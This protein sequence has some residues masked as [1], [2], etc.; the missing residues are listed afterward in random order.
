MGRKAA[1]RPCYSKSMSKDPRNI[2]SLFLFSMVLF[3]ASFCEIQFSWWQVLSVLGAGIL[4]QFVALGLFQLPL[5]SLKSALITCLSVVLLLK[6]PQTSLLVWAVVLSILSKVVIRI[7]D[8]HFFNPS[9]FGIVAVL[10]FWEGAWVSPGQ[11]GTGTVLTFW[12]LAVAGC[13]MV[14]IPR[15]HT[16]IYF[17]SAYA[18]LLTLRVLYLGQPL[19]VLT[20]QLLSGSLLVFSFFMISDP[21]TTP[22]AFLGRVLFAFLVALVAFIFRFSFH[23][24]NALL[25]A[26]FLVSPLTLFIDKIWVHSTYQ[27]QKQN[28]TSTRTYYSSRRNILTR[29][30]F[31]I[32][33]FLRRKSRRQSI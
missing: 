32:L 28:E 4:T 22:N 12:I 18:A 7:R 14:Q 31:G 20:H 10:L 23:S 13:L 3:G 33:W 29:P 9:N 19:S 26:L 6:S 17:L 16:A 24:P 2:Q 1:L 21:R 30:S 25:F 5:N 8:K 15:A 11:W 27:W